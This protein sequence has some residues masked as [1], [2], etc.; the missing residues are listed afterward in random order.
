[1]Q[2]I[3][4]ALLVAI[5]LPVSAVCRWSA[6]SAIARVGCCT[7]LL[8]GMTSDSANIVKTCVDVV[9]L[10][11]PGQS[12]R[13]RKMVQDRPPLNA[14]IMRE[15][16]QRCGFGCVICGR[17]IYE[18]DHILG[19]AKVKRHVASEITLLCDNHHREKTAGFL[20][21]ER[22]IEADKAPFNIS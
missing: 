18:Y 14:G 17:P 21:N 11:Q 6:K 5:E 16:R 7:F 4:L 3:G 2:S 13:R 8:Y 20:P 22:V 15:V 19:W 10:R 9:V 1:M 12:I